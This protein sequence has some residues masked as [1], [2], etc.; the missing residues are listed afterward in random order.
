VL[1]NSYVFIIFFL[2]AAIVCVWFARRVGSNGVAEAT[3]T[4]A[5][6]LFYSWGGLQSLGLL[7]ALVIINYA[8]GLYLMRT[9]PSRTKD[10]DFVLALGVGVNVVVL[11]YFKYRGF[12]IENI[13]FIG[14]GT[15]SNIVIPL[16]ISFFTFQK[17]AF[18]VECWRGQ[19]R[20]CSFRR[21][22]IF[23]S[24]FPQLIAGPIV[25]FGEVGWQFNDIMPER[26]TS[27]NLAIGSTLFIIGL[28]KKLVI[29][30][31]LGLEVDQ[32]FPQLAS[33]QTAGLEPAWRAALFYTFQLYFDF[34]GYS[35]M[36]IGIARMFGI[37]LPLNFFSPYRATSIIEFWRRWHI[38]LSRFLRDFVYIP[39]GG[40]KRGPARRYVNLMGTM[41]IGGLWHGA[42]WTFV[43]WGGLHGLYLCVNHLWR[44]A[45]LPLCL[46]VLPL[47]VRAL[48]GWVITFGAV[49]VAWVFF[50]A[51]DFLSAFAVLR[52]MFYGP[53]VPVGF[54]PHLF[55]LQNNTDF[56]FAI[57]AVTALIMPNAYQ[58]L[59]NYNPAVHFE[60]HGS[61]TF[62]FL[63]FLQWQPSFYALLVILA[64]GCWAVS[65]LDQNREFIYF[66]F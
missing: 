56:T 2:P 9:W 21:F 44:A 52:N 55:T 8:G 12:V 33:G 26:Q 62:G 51:P 5:S 64:M 32:L 7:I 53:L 24:F 27:R 58:W 10:R 28:F 20:D 16:A 29:A 17:I 57:A 11:G 40:N 15:T 38:T 48:A 1:F 30:D 46:R 50:R 47:P 25:R 31:G 23:V 65:N 34:S 4:I 63:R 60:Y 18:L 42:G 45:P 59:R 36:A 61:E 22:L 39:F 3:L 19:V 35:D 43:F 37:I 13:N 66:R 49:I 41:L 6:I 14:Q 54:T